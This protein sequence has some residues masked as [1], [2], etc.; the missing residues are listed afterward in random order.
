MTEMKRHHTLS[1]LWSLGNL[2]KSSFAFILFLFVFRT[3]P[4]STWVFYARII[5][6]IG[7]SIALVSIIWKWFTTRY[8]ADEQAFHIY[9]GAFS[10][11]RSTIPY[12]KVQN[13]SRH[14]SF[15][16]RLFGVTSIRF[17][18]GIKGEEATFQ[19]QVVSVAEAEQL[20]KQMAKY[21]SEAQAQAVMEQRKEQEVQEEQEASTDGHNA[22]ADVVSTRTKS[23]GMENSTEAA[24]AARIVHYRSTRKDVFKASFTSLSFLVLIPILGSL[25]STVKDF[26]PDETVTESLVLSWFESW[27]ITT[28]IILILILISLGLGIVRTFVKYGDFQITSDD[29][30]IYIAKGMLEKT[31]FSIQKDRVQAVKMTQSPLKRM[32]GLAEVELTTA[33]SLGESGQEINSLYPFLPVKEAYRI[34]EELL[35]SYQISEEMEKLPRKAL[36][37]RLLKP[38]WFW[39]IVTGVLVYFKPVLFG[40]SQAWWL[41]SLLLLAVVVAGRIIDF[42]HTRYVLNDQFIQLR[43]GALTSTLFVSKREKVIEVK[44]TRHPLQRRLSLASIHTVNRAKPVMHHHVHDLPNEAAAEFQMWYMG[45]SREVQTR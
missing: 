34:I 10:R 39:I 29:K 38:S 16:H 1:L 44:I 20:E 21:L 6:Y 33:G 19:L 27:W 36:W 24:P 2:I 7:I 43:S 25:Y 35:P 18:T 17:E 32:L 31:A 45:R 42:S 5:F 37:L 11:T 14:T 30:R 28:I 40:L 8:S 9:T 15:F 12:T 41:L 4:V 23:E 22:S 3:G 26:F 13:V